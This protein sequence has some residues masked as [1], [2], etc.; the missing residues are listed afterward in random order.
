[1]S[2]LTLLLALVPL[3]L[4]AAP[5]KASHP[6]A[7]PNPAPDACETCHADATPDA[8]K[9]W[10]GSAHGLTLVKCFVCHGST[11]KDFTRAP[12]PQRCQGCHADEVA[13]VAPAK[14]QKAPAGGCFACHAPHALTAEGKPNPHAR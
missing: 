7:G 1:M 2:R 4:A 9:A 8:V 6:D 12:G 14:G 10:E 13:A 11:G 3:L 5:K